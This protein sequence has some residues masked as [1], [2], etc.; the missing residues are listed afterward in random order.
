MFKHIPNILSTFRIMLVPI[1]AIVF[2][3]G[4]KNASYL[5]LAIFVIAG[6]TDVIDGYMARKYK[7]ITKVGTVLDPL[8][9]KLMQLTALICLAIADAIP[10][11]ITL[12][13]IAKEL[14]MIIT[15]IY[16]YFRKIQTVIP[17]NRF[18]KSATVLF[19]LAIF[20]TI[21]YPD[22]LGSLLL[23]IAA[24]LLKLSALASYIYQ[25]FKHT[26]PNIKTS[27]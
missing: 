4:H 19:S 3:S 25:Y 7:L 26:K 27:Q 23:V 17:S 12:L 21:L 13:V 22:S 24:L 2:F 10:L 8:A 1:F 11:W 9:D 16:M 14:A 5:A 20:I 6:I 15:G 18:G